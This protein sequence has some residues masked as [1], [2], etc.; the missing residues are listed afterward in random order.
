MCVCDVQD[1]GEVEEVGVFAELETG[2]VCVVDVEYWRE[3]LDVA[4]AEDAGGA[5]GAG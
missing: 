1:V 5:E 3:D 4:F 2:A